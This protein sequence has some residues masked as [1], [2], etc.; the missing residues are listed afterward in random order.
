LETMMPSLVNEDVFAIV[1][2][3]IKNECIGNNKLAIL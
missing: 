1:E 2:S 3:L